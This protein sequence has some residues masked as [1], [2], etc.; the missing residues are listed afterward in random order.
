MPRIWAARIAAFFAPALPIDKRLQ[1]AAQRAVVTAELTGI[2]LDLALG[3]I[4][5]A[6]GKEARW[7]VVE[8]AFIRR[9]R[10]R[11]HGTL[12]GCSPTCAPGDRGA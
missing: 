2:T 12:P 1:A 4:V 8:H 9:P 11:R 7:T 3:I 5:D 10:S 6:L